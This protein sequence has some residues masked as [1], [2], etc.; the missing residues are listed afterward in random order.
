MA[1]SRPTGANLRPPAGRDIVGLSVVSWS[2]RHSNRGDRSV[3]LLAAGP[4]SSSIRPS[5]EVAPIIAT[6]AV[7]LGACSMLAVALTSTAFAW[8]RKDTGYCPSRR[9]ASQPGGEGRDRGAVH[10]AGHLARWRRL[11]RQGGARRRARNRPMALHQRPMAMLDS[12]P[13]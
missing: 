6:R 12:I 10:P 13:A 1:K 7:R 5:S 11:G 2:S 3:P 4:P 9:E 8:G